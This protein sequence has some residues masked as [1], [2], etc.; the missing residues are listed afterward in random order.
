MSITYI[1]LYQSCWLRRTYLVSVRGET[2]SKFSTSYCVY[3]SWHIFIIT[4]ALPNLFRTFRQHI[5]FS[6]ILRHLVLFLSSPFSFLHARLSLTKER[7]IFKSYYIIYICNN[8]QG[9]PVFYHACPK[10]TR[11]EKKTISKP[12]WQ[13]FML[14][15]S[16]PEK[17]RLC[18]KKYYIHT[19]TST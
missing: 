6:F 3:V 12:N 16:E 9:T 11:W 18:T 1:K 15:M 17:W 13:T 10:K 14:A 8:N 2:N 7:S 4:V 5:T 19:L